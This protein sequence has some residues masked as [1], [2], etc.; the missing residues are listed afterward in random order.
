M[1][2]EVITFRHAGWKNR[3][4]HGKNFAIIEKK[5]SFDRKNFENALSNSLEDMPAGQELI[6]PLYVI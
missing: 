6:I 5:V 1:L 2:Y 3:I 4:L